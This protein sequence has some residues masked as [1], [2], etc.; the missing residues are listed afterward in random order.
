MVTN[1]GLQTLR[2]LVMNK[3]L[4]DESG[5]FLP[6]MEEFYT[7]QGEGFHT[8]KPA[9]FLRIGGCDV[10]CR[11]CDV[12]ASWN[13][14]LYSPISVN[15]ILKNAQQHKGRTLVVTGG[16]PLMYPMGYLCDVFKEAGFATHIETSGSHELS[17][18]FD[19]I[20]LSPKQN[21]PPLEDILPKANELKVI[22][23]EKM[24]LEWAEENAAKVNGNCQLFL[25]AEWSKR[26]IVM[27]FI[28]DYIKENP[29][30]SVSLQSHKYM[31]IP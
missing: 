1:T 11:W 30:W 23:E 27:P 21:Q 26:N 2:N 25:Q 31:R 20:C 24:D 10:G 3:D 22:I 7:L 8:G 9:Y 13:A 29:K 18:D 16:E 5:Q 6:I 28:I 17:G 4:I 14:S 15:D 12:K 19:W